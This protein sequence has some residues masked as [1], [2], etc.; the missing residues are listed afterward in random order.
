VQLQPDIITSRMAQLMQIKSAHT[1]SIASSPSSS[2]GLVQGS[3]SSMRTN[4]TGESSRSRQ[5][6]STWL[7]WKLHSWVLGQAWGLEICRSQQGWKISLCTYA[8]VSLDS[9]VVEYITDGDIKGLQRIF[10]QGK[11][12]PFTVYL[13]IGLG[14]TR[15]MTLLEV[16]VICLYLY[17]QH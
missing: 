4:R 6:Q 12:S 5:I 13:D 14:W 11:A 9:P 1:A 15:E 10:S 3:P 8:V 16:C 17:L 2:T 7:R